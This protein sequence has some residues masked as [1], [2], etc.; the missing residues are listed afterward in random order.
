[1]EFARDPPGMGIR[2]ALV[3][4]LERWGSMTFSLC[5]KDVYLPHEWVESLA[6]FER[7]VDYF[8]RNYFQTTVCSANFG[9]GLAERLHQSV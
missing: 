2:L 4:G 9:Y 1:M 3:Y 6:E 5:R 8:E 7:A